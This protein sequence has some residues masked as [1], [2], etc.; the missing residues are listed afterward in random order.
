MTW[1]YERH[2]TLPKTLVS[3][4]RS[5]SL[6]PHSNAG[7]PIRCSGEAMPS[8]HCYDCG[9]QRTYVLQPMIQ[10]G[11]WQRPQ[12]CSTDPLE[13]PV[14]STD[15]SGPALREQLATP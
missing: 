14:S 1:N 8:Q 11:P 15:L 9:A 3:L 4:M 7:W 2:E 12:L 10:R 5:V 6:C 13:I